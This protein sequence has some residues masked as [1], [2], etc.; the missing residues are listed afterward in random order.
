VSLFSVN[1]GCSTDYDCQ[2]N[3]VC[4]GGTCHCDPQWNGPNCELLNLVPVP[5]SFKTGYQEH[6]TSS[7]GGSVVKI[8]DVYHMYVS[9]MSGFCGLNCWEGNSEIAHAVSNTPLGP[10]TFSE[11]VLPQFA[12]GPTIHQLDDGTLVLF[13]LGCS[14]P[15]NPVPDHPPC[16]CPYRNGT[17]GGGFISTPNPRATCSS[18]YISLNT[19]PGPNG[20]WTMIG[21]RNP[22][23]G[24]ASGTTNP[25]LLIYANGTALMAYRGNAIAGPDSSNEFLGLAE[26]TTWKDN[27]ASL[28]SSAPIVSHIGEDP[29]IYQDKRGNYHIVYHDMEG[30]DRGGHAFSSNL[31]D[32]YNGPVPCYTGEVHYDDGSSRK[33]QK[34][35]RPQLIFEGGVPQYLYTGVIP[36]GDTGDY[37]FTLAQQINQT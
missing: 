7:W 37:S 24:W 9:R 26:A 17:S 32:W 21:R 16:T 35:Q 10:F 14:T 13:H 18:D 28:D 11:I 19:A 12:H 34:R 22:T 1:S 36:G 6:N 8:G 2:L 4:T 30:A 25:G 20:P 29:Y 31:K 5:S 33:F 15:G 27:F 23:A 3:G